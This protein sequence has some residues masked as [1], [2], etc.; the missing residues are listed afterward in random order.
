MVYG[1]V[2]STVAA[3]LVCSKLQVRVAR[4]EAG[5]RSFD[6]SMPEEVNRLIRMSWPI[7]CLRP[8][9]ARK[10][11]SERE[12]I[13]AERVRLV[14]NVMIDTVLQILPSLRKIHSTRSA[15]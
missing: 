6:R 11:K 8:T 7:S 12:G 4:V 5:L 10:Q 3:A 9:A 2:N 14:G 1:D 15:G 13:P